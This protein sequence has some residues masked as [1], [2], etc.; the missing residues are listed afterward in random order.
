MTR[1]S[2]PDTGVPGAVRLA[3][4]GWLGAILLG[5]AEALVRLALPDPPSA[6]Q[7]A[8]RFG[9][10]LLLSGLVL[11]LLTGH[12]AARWT[13]ALLLGGVGTFSLLVEPA[14]WLLAGGS[15]L[16][17]L[18]AADGPALLIVALRSAH[19]AAVLAALVLMF[20]PAANAFFRS[21]AGSVMPV[22]SPRD[23]RSPPP[24][25]GRDARLRCADVPDADEA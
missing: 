19:V 7:L 18:T 20:R 11:S 21:R 2:A 15:A 25:R 12:N 17:Y 13:V 4:A 23:R 9:M 8:V 6:G 3:V 16:A 24:T 1:T 14:A 5:I 10:Y 22:G